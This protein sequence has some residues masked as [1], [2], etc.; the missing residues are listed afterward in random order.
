MIFKGA[1]V[2]AAF[3]EGAAPEQVNQKDWRHSVPMLIRANSVLSIVPFTTFLLTSHV[4]V[5]VG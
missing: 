3:N 4:L 1:G 5:P 2:Y